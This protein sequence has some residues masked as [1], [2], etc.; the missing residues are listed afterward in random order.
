MV[1]GIRISIDKATGLMGK[2][3][4]AAMLDKI[5]AENFPGFRLDADLRA[6]ILN[7]QLLERNAF[8]VPQAALARM[9]SRQ[10]GVYWGTTGHTT[11]P[12]SGRRAGPGRRALP[13]LYGQHRFR[14]AAAP[15]TG[16]PLTDGS[17]AA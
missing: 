16:E 15:I 6:A 13:R 5:V 8:Y 4:S 17:A 12:R 3:P 14:E 11:E 2:K 1:H 7:G 10:T 9:I